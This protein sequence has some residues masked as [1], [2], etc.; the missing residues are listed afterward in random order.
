M[1]A[2]LPP[3]VVAVVVAAHLPREHERPSQHAWY[4]LSQYAPTLAH[5]PGPLRPP[6][7][8]PSPSSPPPSSLPPLP[9]PSLPFALVGHRP[10]ALQEHPSQHFL[11]L[12]Q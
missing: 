9:P 6:P 3:G 4:C 8:P 11:P 7:P 12:P 10:L 2:G 1:Q 5:L